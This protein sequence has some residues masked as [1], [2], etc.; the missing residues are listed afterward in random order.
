MKCIAAA[1]TLI[2][3]TALAAQASEMSVTLNLT[4]ETGLGEPVGTVVLQ[5]TDYGLLLTPDLTGLTPGMHG[6]HIHANPDCGPAEKDGAMV[7]GLAAGGHYDPEETAA[8]EG[9]YGDGHLGDL[10]PLYVDEE[11]NATIPVLAPRLAV[12]DV[13]ERSLM[14]HMNGDNF[15]DE[16]SPL[17]GGGARLACGVID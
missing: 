9:P 15:S 2:A 16:P 13:R 17:G 3:S 7:P 10:P 5:D 6:F 11:G 1:L 4:S 12:E 14:I 8:H